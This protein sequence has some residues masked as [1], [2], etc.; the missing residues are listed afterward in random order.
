MKSSSLLRSL[1]VPKL[2]VVKNKA[3]KAHQLQT[4]YLRAILSAT[5]S[6]MN[7]EKKIQLTTTDLSAALRYIKESALIRK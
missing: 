3:A 6:P 7:D 5:P 1:F 2:K 4:P